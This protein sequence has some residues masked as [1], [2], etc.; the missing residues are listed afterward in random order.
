[1]F[2]ISASVSARK[3]TEA[4]MTQYDT[5][6]DFT[7]A[8]IFGLLLGSFVEYTVH[9]LMHKG[10]F[11]GKRHAKHHRNFEAQ[12][13]WGEFTDLLAPWVVDRLGRV[14]GFDPRRDRV[15]PRNGRLRC[16]CG[17]CSPDPARETRD[18]LLVRGADPLPPSPRK[19]VAPQLR[20]R[21]QHLG[22]GTRHIQACRLAAGTTLTRLPPQRVREHPL[23]LTNILSPARGRLDGSNRR[24]RAFPPHSICLVNPK[25]PSTQR[26]LKGFH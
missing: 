23:A 5:I 1:M 3:R 26:K 18:R 8:L 11:L 10:K 13:W 12:G 21:S 24:L 4:Y 6:L 14:F 19:H 7:I 16:F 20:D 22:P 25:T 15:R 2:I 17:L 9:R